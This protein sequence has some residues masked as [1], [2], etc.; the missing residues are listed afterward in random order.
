MVGHGEYVDAAMVVR[1]LPV[2][3]LLVQLM[4]ARQWQHP[5]DVLQ[6][7]IPWFEDPLIFLASVSQMERES[8]SL[9]LFAD[10]PRLSELFRVVRGDVRAEPVEL[11]WLDVERAFFIAVNRMP[12]DD[13]ALALDYR[14]DPEQP[15]VVA[16]D[17]WSDP[18]L[19]GW[20]VV[21]PTFSSFAAA[22]GLLGAE[23]VV[24]FA[25]GGADEPVV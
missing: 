22:V 8:R 25:G 20:R 5:G 10:D 16:S 3:G 9:D 18:R 24:P 17:V 19:Y 6:N 7:V 23:P 21:A 13:V 14:S 12:G 2:P 4:A 11:P 1:G 15:R